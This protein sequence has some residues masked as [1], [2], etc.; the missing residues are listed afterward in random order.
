MYYYEAAACMSRLTT[1]H[2]GFD[3]Q[4]RVEGRLEVEHGR[5][6]VLRDA[7]EHLIVG[8]GP[9]VKLSVHLTRVLA[10]PLDHDPFDHEAFEDQD[11]FENPL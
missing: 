6:G 9:D 10:V 3:G 1:Y 5:V 8:L 2:E 4:F 7:L 11:A